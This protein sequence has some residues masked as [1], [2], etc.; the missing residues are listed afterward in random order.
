MNRRD[1]IRTTSML[2]AAA[3]VSAMPQ[4][5]SEALAAATDKW[6]VFEVTT[7]VGVLKPAGATRVWLPLPLVADND[8]QKNLGSIWTVEG[9]TAWPIHARLMEPMFTAVY[10]KDFAW[11]LQKKVPKSVAVIATV[12]VLPSS[13]LLA[14]F[15]SM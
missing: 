11:Q 10:V 7:K 1:F 4:F 12:L 15:A 13:T 6:R 2:P 14:R 8:F 5:V 3:A 9:G